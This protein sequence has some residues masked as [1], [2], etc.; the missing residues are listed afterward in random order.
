MN[1]TRKQQGC[2]VQGPAGW[3]D[4][5]EAGLA[6]TDHQCSHFNSSTT[7]L[8]TMEGR[9]TELLEQLLAGWVGLDIRILLPTRKV[10]GLTAGTTPAS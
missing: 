2:P 5:A 10:Q 6:K 3:R 7:S 4:W 8:K 9:A 1:R